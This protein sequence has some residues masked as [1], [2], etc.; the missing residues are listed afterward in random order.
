MTLQLT[1]YLYISFIT[2]LKILNY[3]L[4]KVFIS[5]SL[6]ALRQ[7]LYAIKKYKEVIIF[8]L[9]LLMYAIV[10]N[11]YLYTNNM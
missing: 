3:Q 4:N 10:H 1:L 9:I 5:M 11:L 8:M 2:D 7:S 6:S